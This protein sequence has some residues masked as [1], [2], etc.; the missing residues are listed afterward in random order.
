[1]TVDSSQMVILALGCNVSPDVNMLRM[2]RVL[3]R[4]FPLLRFTYQMVTTA[5]G[6]V[7]Q[8]FTNCLAYM[9]AD[10]GYS[11]LHTITKALELELGSTDTNKQEGR[12]VADIDIL[13]CGG[14]KYHKADWNRPYIRELINVMARDADYREALNEAML[15]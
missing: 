6:I 14:H 7:A 2:Q 11:E 13:Y 5:I 8:P 12:V 1:M 10:I 3:S 9:P 15:L 4:R